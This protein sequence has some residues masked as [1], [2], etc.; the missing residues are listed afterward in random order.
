MF[1]NDII[2]LNTELAKAY[3]LL[4]YPVRTQ[5]S[6]THHVN[7]GSANSIVGLD[8]MIVKVQKPYI[9]I[10]THTKFLCQSNIK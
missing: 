3:F 1:S 2:S 5:R 8:D 4:A 7:L 6:Y 10:Y 9:L